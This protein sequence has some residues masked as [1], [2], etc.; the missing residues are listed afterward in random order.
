MKRYRKYRKKPVVVEA[1]QLNWKNWNDVCDFLENVI[2]SNNP[3]R[4]V[5][6]YSDKCGEDGPTY[7][8]ITIP[9]LEGN[10]I[11]KHGDYIIKGVHG[12]FYSCKPDIF[13][14]T[15]EKTYTE[16]L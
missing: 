12:E 11:V 4:E 5:R 1:I 9:T 2:T 3:G 8:E 6:T 15:H 7:L 16:I 13:E 14:K 10:C